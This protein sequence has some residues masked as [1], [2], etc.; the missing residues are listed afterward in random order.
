MTSP[1]GSNVVDDALRRAVHAVASADALLITAGA[2]MG[3]DSGLPDFRG[4]EGFWRAY[5]AFQRLGLDF[6][7]LANPRWFTADPTLAWGFYGHRL[8]LYRTATPHAGFH[9]LRSWARRMSLGAFVA[10]SN[11]DGHFQRAGFDCTRVLEVHGT[12]HRMQCTRSCGQDVF[13][14]DSVEVAVDTTTLRACPPLPACSACGA[15]ARPNIL[16]FGDWDWDSR[17]ANVQESRLRDW[18]TTVHGRKFVI[19]ECGA[20]Q[21]IPTIRHMSEAV[22]DRPGATLVRINPREPQVPSGG[23]GLPLGA[24]EALRAISARMPS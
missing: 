4:K 14:A 22:A 2:G 9:I 8:N 6:P 1:R 24:L 5:P 16:L 21:A 20:G 15:L 19:V 11:V 10:T 3:V 7:S 17:Q 23:I 18:L 13:P 12:I